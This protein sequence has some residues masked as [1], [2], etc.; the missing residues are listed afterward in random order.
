[1]IT[2]SISASGEE[3]SGFGGR[4]WDC[5]DSEGSAACNGRSRFKLIDGLGY[6]QVQ[7]PLALRLDAF[8]PGSRTSGVRAWDL[9]IRV[10]TCEFVPRRMFLYARNIPSVLMLCR[11]G[12]PA[13]GPCSRCSAISM[14]I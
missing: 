6:T 8:H 14:L 11:V 9:A 3:G 1:L 10:E 2:I 7:R 12:A 5:S 13:V 4:S